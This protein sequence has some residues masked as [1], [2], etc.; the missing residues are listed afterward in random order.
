MEPNATIVAL[1]DSITWGY[2]EGP[3]RSWVAQVAVALGVIIANHG[4]NGDTLAG[5]R[6]RL[7]VILA[8]NKPVAVIVTG[9]ANDVAMGRR[10]PD[11]CADLGAMVEAIAASGAF[12]VI[13]MPVPI[14]IP[15]MES[16]LIA[17]RQFIQSLAGTRHLRVIPFQR[18]LSDASGRPRREF[19]MDEC[20]PNADGFAAMARLVI[21]GEFL[22]EVAGG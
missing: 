1:G 8:E 2:P 11:M 6:A 10:V 20:H 21:G 7:P 14:L 19:F 22:R 3:P 13:G 17:Y 16:S 18:A 4:V 12:P 15:Q 9:G 5:M